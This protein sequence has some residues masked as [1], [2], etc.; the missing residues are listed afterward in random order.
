MKIVLAEKKSLLELSLRSFC[1]D[2]FWQISLVLKVDRCMNG[3][4]RGFKHIG[5]LIFTW[6]ISTFQKQLTY[7]V[8]DMNWKIRLWHQGQ[9][10]CAV[11]FKLHD[12]IF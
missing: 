5:T 10:K 1:I 11:H 12:R 3:H 9:R 2:V 4:L 8:Q 7:S 6:I